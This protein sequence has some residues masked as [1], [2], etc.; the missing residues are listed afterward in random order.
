MSKSSQSISQEQQLGLRLNPQQVRF[1]RLL[2]MSAPEYEEE[3]AR[4]LDE[5]P[6]LEAVGAADDAQLHKDDEGRDF[7]ESAEELRLRLGR[8]GAVLPAVP[9]Q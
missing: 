6:A 2:E 4:A 1:G 5:N 9:R 3:V 8:G 7:T